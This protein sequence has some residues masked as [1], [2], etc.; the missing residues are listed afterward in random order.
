[1]KLFAVI[2]SLALLSACAH[3]ANIVSVAEARAS[4]SQTPTRATVA[5]FR[6]RYPGG[7]ELEV[8]RAGTGDGIVLVKFDGV[9]FERIRTAGED[10]QEY[11]RATGVL[12]RAPVDGVL[13][14]VVLVV[15]FIQTG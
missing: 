14:R 6:V 12:L 9:K 15:D 11:I 1:M 4:A 10:D 13:D 5:G 8:G 7:D 3:R 2:L